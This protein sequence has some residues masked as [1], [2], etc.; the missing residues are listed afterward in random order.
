M[1]LRFNVQWWNLLWYKS[2]VTGCRRHWTLERKR[3]AQGCEFSYSTLWPAT[4]KLDR[5][6]MAFTDK[7]QAHRRGEEI[8]SQGGFRQGGQR[9]KQVETIKH[10]RGK[11]KQAWDR[12]MVPYLFICGGFRGVA[13]MKGYAWWLSTQGWGTARRRRL[14]HRKRD[15][16]QWGS[17]GCG[18]KSPRAEPPGQDRSWGKTFWQEELQTALSRPGQASFQ[19]HLFKGVLQLRDFFFPRANILKKIQTYSRHQI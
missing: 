1:V 5:W 7:R 6:T 10:Y 18:I 14:E 4:T 16:Q 15:R 19:L 11:T 8:L 13:G 2:S 9:W 17:E 3:Y 12:K